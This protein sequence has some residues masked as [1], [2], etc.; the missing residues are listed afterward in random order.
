MKKDEL[1]KLGLDEEMAEKVAN[2][3]QEELRGYIP[4][5][6]FD[7]VNNEKKNLETSLKERD[8]Q[9]ENLKNSSSDIEAMKKEI[10]TLQSDNKK[11][12]EA[13]AAEIKKLKIDTAVSLAL[14]NAKAKNEKAVKALLDIDLEKAEFTEEGKLK[15]LDEQIKNLVK[16]EDTKFLFEEGSKEVKFKGAVPGVSGKVDTDGQIDISKMTY[17]ELAA[18]MAENPDVK[19]D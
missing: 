10:E 19:I 16:G 13:H 1:L 12:D 6:R 14:S 4:K 7:E 11:K 2:A 9:L 17:S 3:S 5:A 15:G 18:Y 8:T